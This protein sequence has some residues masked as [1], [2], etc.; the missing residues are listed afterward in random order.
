[1]SYRIVEHNAVAFADNP[2]IKFPR[3]QRKQTWNEKDNFKLCISVFKG[4]PIGVVIV[5][6]QNG[7]DFLLDGRQRRNALKLMKDDPKSVY[8]WAKAFVKFNYT[9]DEDTLKEMFWVSI[10]EYLQHEASRNENNN[11]AKEE[12]ESES[13]DSE[14]ESSFNQETYENSYDFDQQYDSLKS[15]LD[16]V[17]LC[18]PFKAAR[19]ETI[20]KTRLQRMYEFN[21]I[22]A[23]DQLDYAETE[24]G[25]YVINHSRLKRFI[26][27][28][29]KEEKIETAEDFANVLM[30]KFRLTDKESEKMKRFVTQHWDYYDSS[31]KVIGR[32]NDVIGQ[33]TVGMISLTNADVLD[34]QNIFSL[35]NHSGTPLSAEEL[36]SARPFWN[37]SLRNPSAELVE[38]KKEMYSFLEI[39]IPDE[40]C[41]WDISATFL[42]RIDT[43]G[44]IFGKDNA[45]TTIISLSFRLIS[46][47][48]VDGINNTS[49]T[50][51]EKKQ[52]INWEVDIEKLIKEMK[53]MIDFIEDIDYFKYMLAWNQSV[54]SLTS[55]SIALEFCSVLFKRFQELGIQTK[56]SAN[57]SQFCRDAVVLFDRLVY[58]YSIRMWT[59]SSDSAVA[60]HLKNISQRFILI[61]QK[62]WKSFINE[63]DSGSYKGKPTSSS[64]LKPFLYHS[65]FLRK[66]MPAFKN[67]NTQYDIDHLIAKKFFDS[68]NSLPQQF[69]NNYL[70]FSIL[71]KG[72]NIEKTDKK[73]NEIH[74]TWLIEQIKK[75]A[76]IT[77]DDIQLFSNLANVNKL[78]KRKQSYLDAYTNLRT[79]LFANL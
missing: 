7:N 41:R 1:M 63:I 13:Q 9:E 64:T 22:I 30:R 56:S 66:M 36:L 65:Y 45:F 68:N 76:N 17:L 54:L 19:N 28:I 62:E 48:F 71:P 5:N 42:N 46:S 67:A 6:S 49:V 21:N 43:N 32:I 75:Y 3:F 8:L 79:D 40:T 31:L 60:N 4:Y 25:D 58:E 74:D 55:N 33:A 18:H 61:D 20:K 53:K 16:F 23:I 57:Y 44:L 72:E 11:N 10:D 70:N 47:L 29:I 52:T 77:D 39:P 15:L 69:K 35:V 12:G 14:E 27:S 34:A 50:Q 26:D 78:V 73:L 24:G 37:V 51:L 59:G 38:R 2:R